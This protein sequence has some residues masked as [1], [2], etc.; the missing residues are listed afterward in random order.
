[1]RAG[2]QPLATDGVLPPWLGWPGSGVM[3]KLVQD[4]HKAFCAAV[5]LPRIRLAYFKDPIPAPGGR[6]G[7]PCGYVLLNA[8]YA[9]EAE[10]R[11]WPVMEEMGAHSDIV[12]RSKEI[13][14]A[15]SSAAHGI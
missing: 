6:C 4:E 2:L 14:A 8:A 5:K 7:I 11:G 15:I 1:V 3:L 9:A 12:A 13:A 10:S